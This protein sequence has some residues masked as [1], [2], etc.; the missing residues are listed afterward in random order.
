MHNSDSSEFGLM[1]AGTTANNKGYLEAGRIQNGRLIIGAPL[2]VPLRINQIVSQQQITGLTPQN[3]LFT[4]DGISV[5][6]YQL[7]ISTQAFR[8]LSTQSIANL[9]IVLMTN[10][11]QLLA[12]SNVAP[13]QVLLYNVLARGIIARG[14]A[15]I[16][17][18]QPTHLLSI[19][20]WLVWNTNNMLYRAQLNR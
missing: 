13:W 8:R 16:A 12:V 18:D 4:S 9:Q 14:T 7:D 11:T 3:M 2:T 6:Q 1:I 5:T 20:Q 17:Q 15:V 10:P 19:G